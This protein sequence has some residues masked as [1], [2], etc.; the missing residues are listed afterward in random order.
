[1]EWDAAE[2]HFRHAVDFNRR[3]QALPWEAQ[4]QHQ[5]ARMLQQRGHSGDHGRAIELMTEALRIAKAL[6]M[7]GLAQ[8]IEARGDFIGSNI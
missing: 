6:G 2:A 1:M 4:A 7:E 3:L 5:Y 8:E